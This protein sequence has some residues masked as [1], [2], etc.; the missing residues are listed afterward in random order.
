MI[1]WTEREKYMWIAWD[2]TTCLCGKT[3]TLVAISL[4]FHSI[5][6][7]RY[8]RCYVGTEYVRY[9]LCICVF[10]VTFKNAFKFTQRGEYKAQFILRMKPIEIHNNISFFISILLFEFELKKTDPIKIVNKIWISLSLSSFFLCLLD[11]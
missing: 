4:P 8:T 2:R 10:F 3:R 9:A 5:D 1:W 11:I 7:Y 6:I